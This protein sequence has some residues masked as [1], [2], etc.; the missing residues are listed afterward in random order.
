MKIMKYTMQKEERDK[1]VEDEKKRRMRQHEI[2]IK[3]F[4]DNQVKQKHA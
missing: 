4:L 1:A 2:N 3:Y